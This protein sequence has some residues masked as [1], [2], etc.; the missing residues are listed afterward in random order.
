M[1]FF[2]RYIK[3]FFS[4]DNTLKTLLLKLILSKEEKRFFSLISPA[5]S[6]KTLS[7]EGYLY[8]QGWWNGLHQSWHKNAIGEHVPWLTYPCIAFVTPLLNK[9]LS[10]LEFGG[11]SST[12][13]WAKH[14]HE[15]ITIEHDETWAKSLSN[16]LPSNSTLIYQKLQPFDEFEAAIPAERYHIV[17]VDGRERVKC[18][19]IALRRLTL[20]GII[21]LDDSN[22][23]KYTPGRKSLIKA[24]FKELPFWGLRHQSMQMTC[25]SIFYRNNNCL[26]I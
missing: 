20:D 7:K 24:G 3:H 23:S 11:G 18:L 26:G 2:E 6:V 10:V 22:R 14:T 19:P 1:I 17:L 13:Y 16:M 5:D 15:V 8:Q 4:R 21:I 9:Q 25:T 12:F